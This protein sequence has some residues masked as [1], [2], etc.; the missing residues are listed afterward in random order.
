MCVKGRVY[1]CEGSCISVLT[2]MY[3][4]AKGHVYVADRLDITEI[5]LK[6]R[7]CV[8]VVINEKQ[9]YNIIRT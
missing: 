6:C 1:M 8:I 9:K 5:L 7:S 3:M 4:C 2:V